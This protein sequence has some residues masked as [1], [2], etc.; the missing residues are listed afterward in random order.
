MVWFGGREV[1][2]LGRVHLGGADFYVHRRRRRIYLKH[3][4]WSLMGAGKTLA[5]AEVRLREEADDIAEILE[6]K[7]PEKLSIEAQKL[8]LCAQKIRAH[9]G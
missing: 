1:M 8:L 7:R 6:R 9:V 5:E 2:P 4:H 3:S